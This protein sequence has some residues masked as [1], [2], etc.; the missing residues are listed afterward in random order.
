[1]L[2][3]VSLRSG[4]A[5]DLDTAQALIEKLF[6]N[7]KRYDLGDVGR[8]RMNDKLKLNIPETTT[9]L[10]PEDII[11]IMKYII[12][13]K[14]GNETVDDIDHLGNRRIRTVGEQLRTAV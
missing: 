11:A 9:V 3:I 4:E 1:M 14:N 13:L 6:F 2:Y 12:N 8:H 10:T 7:D 5:P